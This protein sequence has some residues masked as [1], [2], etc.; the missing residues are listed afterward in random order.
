MKAVASILLSSLMI[1]CSGVPS[2][3]DSNESM[4]ASNVVFSIQLV[5]CNRPPISFRAVDRNTD[6]LRLYAELKGSNDVIELI[7]IFQKSL[8]PVV[9]REAMTSK[10]CEL[11]KKSL[12]D[13]SSK[14]TI[15][16]MGRFS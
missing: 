8:D 11:K 7:D 16:I 9:D 15:A 5:D 4:L 6:R 12:I 3:Y 14:M 2:F 13:Q 10:Y 1:G